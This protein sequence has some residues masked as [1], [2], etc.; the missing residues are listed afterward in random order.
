M[1]HWLNNY[2]IY[3]PKEIHEKQKE[4]NYRKARRKREFDKNFDMICKLYAA[5]KTYN[6][7]ANEICCTRNKIAG[8]IRRSIQKGSLNRRNK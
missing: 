6:E 2:G 4:I 7:I 8:I 5:N 3:D 1:K